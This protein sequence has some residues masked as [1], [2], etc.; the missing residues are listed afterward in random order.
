MQKE[1]IETMDISRM[2]EH[3]DQSETGVNWYELGKMVYKVGVRVATNVLIHV[4]L[5]R[6][7][8]FRKNDIRKWVPIYQAESQ[9]YA[10][11]IR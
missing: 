1:N 4:F 8:D 3:L 10:M 11:C 2:E 7:Q 5:M 9:K 6:W